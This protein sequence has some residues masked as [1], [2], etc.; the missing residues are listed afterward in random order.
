LGLDAR[1]GVAGLTFASSLAGWVELA[2]LRGTLNRR[3]GHTGLDPAFVATLGGAAVFG[4]VAAWGVKF[5]VAPQHPV[6]SAVFVLGTY[7]LMYFGLT[8][9]FGVHE[10]QVAAGRW[11]RAARSSLGGT[12]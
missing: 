6:P 5:L 3:I 10:A 4:A 7:S 11:L 2:L 8:Y 9:G 1:W 12:R